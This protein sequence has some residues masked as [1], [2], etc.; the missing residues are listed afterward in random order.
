MLLFSPDL[1]CQIDF[2]TRVLGLKLSDR[3][4]DFPPED[5]LYLW[6]PPVPSDFGENKELEPR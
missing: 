2:Y 4:R 1:E 6:G 5:S 3:S